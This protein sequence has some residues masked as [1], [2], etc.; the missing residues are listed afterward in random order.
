MYLFQHKNDCKKK[1][2]INFKNSIF[3]II[4]ANREEENY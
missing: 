2:A 1:D 4:R 3:F